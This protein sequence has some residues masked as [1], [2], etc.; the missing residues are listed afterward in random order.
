MEM[1]G[2]TMT[3][4]AAADPMVQKDGVAE[5][6]RPAVQRVLAAEASVGYNMSLGFPGGENR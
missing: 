6:A 1:I 4:K 3:T 5:M 2:E